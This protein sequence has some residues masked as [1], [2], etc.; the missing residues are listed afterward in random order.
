MIP[1]ALAI[2]VAACARGTAPE[3]TS[4][5]PALIEGREI[6]V[7]QCSSC[8]GL[9][10]GGGRGSKL[11]E[12]RVLQRYPDVADQLALIVNGRNQMPAF[13]D[14][15]DADQLDAVI[16]YTREVLAVQG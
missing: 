4:N 12:E 10:G 8:H 15:L 14:K 6:Y 3:V 13:G 11:S 1:I 7:R 5:D 16:R 2:V 9:T